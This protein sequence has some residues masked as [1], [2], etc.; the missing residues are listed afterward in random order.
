[1]FKTFIHYILDSNVNYGTI[2]CLEKLINE[3]DDI[4]KESSMEEKS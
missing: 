1:M 2:G 4:I 3:V